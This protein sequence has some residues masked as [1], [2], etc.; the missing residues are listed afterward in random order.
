MARGAKT[1][2]GVDAKRKVKVRE[3]PGNVNGVL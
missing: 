2:A 3:A 1:E